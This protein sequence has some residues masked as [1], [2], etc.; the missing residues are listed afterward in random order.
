MAEFD[1]DG[2]NALDMEVGWEGGRGEM[3]TTL[4]P[5]GVD[6]CLGAD[7][8]WNDFHIAAL[9]LLC[10][11]RFFWLADPGGM[12]LG[13]MHAWVD[14]WGH[15]PGQKGRMGYAGRGRKQQQPL[16]WMTSIM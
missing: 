4:E 6:Q 5:G 7:S 1:L 9:G 15:L 3:T 2:D 16:A 10:L 11:V 8:I 12:C 13:T 14:A